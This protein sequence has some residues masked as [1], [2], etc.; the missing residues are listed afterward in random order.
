MR[1]FCLRTGSLSFSE[2][3][4]I[5]FLLKNRIE[6]DH[7]REQRDHEQ[8]VYGRSK[9]VGDVRVKGTA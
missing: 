4:E 7:E 5:A 9:T 2:S 6:S 3:A 1:Q 8:L